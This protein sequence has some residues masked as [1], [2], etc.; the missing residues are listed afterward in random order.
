VPVPRLLAIALCAL[1]LAC[2][3][4]VADSHGAKVTHFTV[5][6]R[7]VDQKMRS[8]LVVPE[9]GGRGLLVFLHGRGGD[10]D[11]HLR[12]YVLGPL[13]ALGDRAPTVVFPDGGESSYWH[14][15]RSGDWARYV[16]D[17]VIPEAL[18]RSRAAD[19]RVAIGGISMGGFGAF[20]IARLF[21][22]R[23]CAAG[24]HS[25]A[26]WRRAGESAPGAFDDARDFGRHH[27]VRL[28]ARRPERFS[29]L[30]LWAD[31]GRADPFAGGI[32]TFVANLRA[33]DVAITFKR[34]AGGHT[35]DYWAAHWD[36]YL[37]FYARALSAC[38]TR[39]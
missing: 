22:R 29:G 14:R 30:R 7:F 18:G 19:R 20:D 10:E 2:A 37:R 21:P 27:L 24:G 32:G 33:N 6:S 23:F 11:S 39:T 16:V 4:P 13:N 17:E 35:G 36:E 25:A 15:R 12:P 26:I 9:G 5:Q 8:T 31:T 1:L 38:K 28:A 34:W 3:G